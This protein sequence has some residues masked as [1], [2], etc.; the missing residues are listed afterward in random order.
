MTDY[1]PLDLGPIR[2]RADECSYIESLHED[3]LTASDRSALDVPYLLAEVVRLR[4]EVAVAHRNAEGGSVVVLPGI[5]LW[6]AS[7]GCPTCQAAALD[8]WDPS[9][10]LDWKPEAP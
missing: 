10:P 6:G 2:E 8:G 7:C 3:H 4:R 9:K 5:A 1:K